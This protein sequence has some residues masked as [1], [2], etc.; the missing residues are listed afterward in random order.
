MN[1]EALY[2]QLRRLDPAAGVPIDPA[3]GPRAAALMEQ[4]MNTPFPATDASPSAPV[5]APAR[6]R[7]PKLALA[8]A[9]AVAVVGGAA[10]AV[11]NIGGNDTA[12]KTSV[13]FAMAA[14]NPSM[15]CIN[16][17]GFQPPAGL[18]GLRGT[19]T[20][21]AE[22][23]IT[24]T[25]DHWF[26]GGTADQVVLTAPADGPNALTEG[27]IEFSVGGQYLVA[28]LDGQV[29]TCGV[30]GPVDPA[31]EALYAKWFPA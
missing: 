29:Q 27:G 18:V 21:V 8:A 11:A 20:A 10:F 14:P 1:D 17:D 19:V 28:A 23:S 6:S 15:M 12:K 3:T 16:L 26:A 31:L 22:G 4:I 13:S 25:V 24:L 9:A 2:E 30:S 5:P 7:W